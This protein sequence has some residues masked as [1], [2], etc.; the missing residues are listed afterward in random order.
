[1]TRAAV[2]IAAS[3]LAAILLVALLTG[4]PTAYT[5]QRAYDVL[6]VAWSGAHVVPYVGVGETAVRFRMQKN[7]HHACR[8]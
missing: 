3:A 1:M 5:H 8:L 4:G 6:E 7:T 2:L